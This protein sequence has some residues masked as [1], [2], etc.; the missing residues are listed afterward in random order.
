MRLGKGFFQSFKNVRPLNQE[1]HSSGLVKY[2]Y[3][4]TQTWHITH[5]DSRE[6]LQFSNGQEEVRITLILTQ[7]RFCS[8]AMGR[9]R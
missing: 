8:S 4:Q 3:S 6:V 2:L 7:E 1:S 9:R 5:P